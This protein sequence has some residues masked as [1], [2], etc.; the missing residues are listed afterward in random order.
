MTDV[1][2]L[3]VSF[4]FFFQAEDGIRDLTVTGVQTCALPI[5]A[6]AP[7]P[8]APPLKTA[9]GGTVRALAPLLFSASL[10]AGNWVEMRRVNS[11]PLSPSSPR[12]A[13]VF[14]T[15]Y[16]AGGPPPAATAP[17]HRSVWS[18]RR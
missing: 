6:L 5:C 9:G 16:A 18:P 3:I 7:A 4:F 1:C 14:S 11:P 13:A 8:G 12:S 17:Y 2:G 10:R 15:R